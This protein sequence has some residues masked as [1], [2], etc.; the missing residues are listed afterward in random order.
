MVYLLDANVLIDANRDYYPLERV[1]EFW[2]WL[3]YNGNRGVVKTPVEIHE[4]IKQGNDNLAEWIKSEQITEALVLDA[5]PDPNLVNNAVQNG[6][7]PD[8]TDDEIVKLGRDPFLL[9]YAL[10]DPADYCIVTTEVS[11][12]SRTR[13]NRHLPDAA[14]RL[15]IATCNTFQFVRE[16]DFST[17]WQ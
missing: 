15:D 10:V 3:E 11:K 7:A 5:E 6:Y 8:L 12:P 4:E 14:N 13:A 17:S 1:P 2:D 9:G 16:L